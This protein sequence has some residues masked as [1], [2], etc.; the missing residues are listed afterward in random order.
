[1]AFEIKEMKIVVR[2]DDTDSSKTPKQKKIDKDSLI[3]ECVDQVMEILQN[4]LE[5]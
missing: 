4:K 2:V 1:M 5:R 3:T